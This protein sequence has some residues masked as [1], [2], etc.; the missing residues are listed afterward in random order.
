MKFILI[1]LF[2][3]Q[4]AFLLEGAS[5]EEALKEVED[6]VKRKKLEAKIRKMY[7]AK[8]K[9]SP[10]DY[11][12]KTTDQLIEIALQAQIMQPLQA[13]LIHQEL[14]K[15]SDFKS[16]LREKI[17]GFDVSLI[18][19]TGHVRYRVSDPFVL[20]GLSKAGGR[21]F[22]VETI[23][24]CINHPITVETFHGW[25]LEPFFEMLSSASNKNEGKV[26]DD[27]ILQGRI[28]RGSNV[29]KKWREKFLESASKK[30]L[31]S[32]QREQRTGSNEAVATSKDN[33]AKG[34]GTFADIVNKW[35]V[36]IAVSLL[37]AITFFWMKRKEKN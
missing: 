22:H 4:F 28:E 10:P 32:K 29:E 11:S 23:K 5:L 15:R 36:Y 34:Q 18:D 3:S 6:P 30:S 17:E 7:E 27:L 35:P 14:E 16:T 26:L 20:A 19:G 13:K 31:Y 25:G 21:D 12:N 33:L 37:F 24:K 9:Y 8:A 1:F 2:F